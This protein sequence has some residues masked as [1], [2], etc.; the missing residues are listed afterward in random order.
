MTGMIW[1]WS[2]S[3]YELKT[4]IFFVIITGILTIIG[5]ID[6]SHRIIPI[7]LIISGLLILSMKI[8]LFPEILSTSLWGAVTGFSYLGIVML[9]T[10]FFYKKETMGWGDLL[11]I[12]ILGAWIGPMNI[13]F[14]ILLSA[15][16][17][18]GYWFLMGLLTQFDREMEI[19][20]GFFLSFSAIIV[21]TLDI[22]W[23][24]LLSFP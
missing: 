13:G 16:S 12:I 1:L 21:H 10:K 6:L 23:K 19:P 2:F 3:Q 14:T 22:N 24:N 7:S 4:A 8:S 20:F 15:V 11:L 18:L 5:F 17:G 9:I